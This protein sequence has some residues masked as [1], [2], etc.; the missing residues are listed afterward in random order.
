MAQL[1]VVFPD[2]DGSVEDGAACGRE[3]TVLPVR[4][5]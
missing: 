1:G 4:N 5:W 3:H 2:V